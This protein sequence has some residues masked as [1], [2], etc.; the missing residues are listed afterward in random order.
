MG[1]CKPQPSHAID[2]LT[3]NSSSFFRDKVQHVRDMTASSSP[4]VF[5]D[6]LHGV[7]LPSLAV[8]SAVDVTTATGRLPDKSSAADPLP[9]SVLK[10]IA[11]LVAPFVA[12]LSN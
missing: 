8:V 6:A 2:G 12:D 3:L 9:T 11:D 5:V 10:S 1:Q 7:V 4:S